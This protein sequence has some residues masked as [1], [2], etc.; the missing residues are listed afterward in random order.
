MLICLAVI[1]L[2]AAWEVGKWIAGQI[3]NEWTPGASQR[4][5]R[6]LKKLRDATAAAI[7]MEMENQA[8]LQPEAPDSTVQREPPDSTVRREPPDSTVRREPPDSTV[9]R[10]PPDSTDRRERAVGQNP[11]PSTPRVLRSFEELLQSPSGSTVTLT[12]APEDSLE[13]ERVAQDTVMLMTVDEIKAGLRQE[14]SGLK[15]ELAARLSVKLLNE[16]AGRQQ[17]TT[18]QLKY[19][20]WLWRRHSLGFKYHLKWRDINEKG[21]ISAWL[22]TWKHG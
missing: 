3:A 11:Q 19:V 4:K 2:V 16:E 22:A 17:P 6:K 8:R 20:L 13:R 10:E 5:L 21:R 1:G 15:E 14:G 18:R 7:R 9:R 12:D